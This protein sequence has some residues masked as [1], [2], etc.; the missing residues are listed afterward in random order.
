M[1]PALAREGTIFVDGGARKTVRDACAIAGG[2]GAMVR[3]FGHDDPAE[4]ENLLRQPHV[5]PRVICIDGI[6]NVTG[7]HHRVR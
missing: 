4:L 3:V 6:N 2:Q 7:V 1:I 5:A